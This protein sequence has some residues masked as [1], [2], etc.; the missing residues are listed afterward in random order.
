MKIK[1]ITLHPFAGIIDKT[2]EFDGGLNVVFGDNEAGKSTLMKALIMVLF[3][4]TKQTPAREEKLLENLLPA[5]GGDFIAV[6]LEFEFEQQTYLLKKQWGDSKFSSLNKINEAPISNPDQVQKTLDEILIQNK[7]VWENVMFTGQAKLSY[8]QKDIEGNKEISSVL[9]SMLQNSIFNNAG[10]APEA[11]QEL[12]E[13]QL[14]ELIDNWDLVNN[15]PVIGSKNKGSYDNP[16][17]INIGKILKLDYDIHELE[18]KCTA[19]KNHDVEYDKVISNIQVF[20]ENYHQ[21][22]KSFLDIHRDRIKEYRGMV[23]ILNQKQ[24]AEEKFIEIDK[25]YKDWNTA[26]SQIKLLEINLE[27]DEKSKKEI[28][29]ELKNAEKKNQG[30]NQRLNFEKINKLNEEIE[31]LKGEQNTLAYIKDED[32]NIINEINEKLKQESAKFEALKKLQSFN[33]EVVSVNNIT[34]DIANGNT[35]E[36]RIDLFTATPHVFM[37]E[38]GFELKSHELRIKVIAEADE[39][40][41]CED[42][43]KKTKQTQEEILIKYQ[44]DSMQS[45]YD[46]NKLW[47][48]L[49][50]KIKSKKDLVNAIL[51]NTT[52]EGLKKAAEELQNM[53]PTRS[54][55]VL[56]SLFESAVNKV[57]GSRNEHQKSKN[58]IEA[59]ILK[60]QSIDN[61]EEMKFEKKNEIKKLTDQLNALTAFLDPG[62]DLNELISN[63][64]TKSE[65]EN[66]FKDQLLNMERT[67]IELEGQSDDMSTAEYEDKISI[68]TVEKNQFIAEAKA[69]IKVKEKLDEITNRTSENPYEK[70]HNR[71]RHYISILSGGKY[72]DFNIDKSLPESIKQQNNAALKLSMLSQ[73]TSGLLGMALRLSMADYFLE[74]R[75]GFLIMDDPM[76]DMDSGRQTNTVSCLNDYAQKRQVI[77]F[78][79]HQSHADQFDGNRIN[80]N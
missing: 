39:L 74:N 8:T 46:S 42:E 14:E 17:K 78:T 35:P 3:E 7:L 28:E 68:L 76:T 34:V 22:V 71:M 33:V 29:E 63:Y 55:E 37:A 24:T 49:E 69:I 52:F 73:G 1:K 70:Y 41:H 4:N 53:L 65:A 67:K 59:F 43:I 30:E 36:T 11:L 23:N 50:G 64:D 77:V 21:E 25:D 6:D 38:G 60:Y 72:A 32:K 51:G 40:K 57:T 13:K 19:R 2:F 54:V 12:I 48:E 15:K 79:C 66:L 80:L 5:D 56:R 26:A 58:F 31:A 61:L 75:E 62:V 45:L 16:H 47:L 9:D 27:N 20:T 44:I 18:Q 10:I